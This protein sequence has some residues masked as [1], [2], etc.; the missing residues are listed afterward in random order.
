MTKDEQE[1]IEKY[2]YWQV[3]LYLLEKQRN[4]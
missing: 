3:Q 4:Y 1:Q 2:L